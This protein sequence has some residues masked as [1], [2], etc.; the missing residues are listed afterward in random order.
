VV[1]VV[2]PRAAAPSVVVIVFLLLLLFFFFFQ[3]VVAVRGVRDVVFEPTDEGG[4]SRVVLRG[5]QG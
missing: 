2:L 3:N 5:R 4:D 1:V